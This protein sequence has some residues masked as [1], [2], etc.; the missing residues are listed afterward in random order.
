MRR[1]RAAAPPADAPTPPAKTAVR[2]VDPVVATP[3]AA[4]PKL[5]LPTKLSPP[6]SQQRAVAKTDT[7]APNADASATPSAPLQLVAPAEA[8]AARRSTEAA[9]QTPRPPMRRAGAGAGRAEGRAGRAD[10]R[11][12]GGRRRRLGGAAR[13]AAL[14]SRR[15]T[16]RLPELKK[17]Y[18]EALGDSAL[19]IRQ[20]EVKGEAIYRV[21][22]SGLSKRDAERVARQAE[23]GR[24][25]LLHRQGLSL[26]VLETASSRR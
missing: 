5:N 17:K 18:A 13:R 22:V 14:R 1:R 7:T 9:G 3:E 16:A 25:R 23:G 4:T 8:G 11:G 2:A 12:A 20:A 26:S 15:A 24:Q 21:R 19:S 10:C 6:K